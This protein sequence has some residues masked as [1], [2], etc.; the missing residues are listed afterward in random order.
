VTGKPAVSADFAATGTIAQVVYDVGRAQPASGNLAHDARL[1]YDA[2]ADSF[3]LNDGTKATTFAAGDVSIGTSNLLR[4]EKVEGNS[5]TQL[6]LNWGMRSD[7]TS[8]P[9]YVALGQ[10]ISKKTELATGIDSYR[11]VDFVFGLPGE[12]AFVPVTGSATYAL[13]FRGT[14]SSAVTEH[15]L[16][17]QGGGTALVDFSTGQLDIVGTTASFNFGG[18]G[19]LGTE[20]RGE[21]KARAAVVAGENRFTGTFTA[22]GGASDTYVGSLEGS[23]FGP[24]SED[25]GGVLYGAS[26]PLYYNLAFAGYSLPKLRSDDTLANLEGT[27]RLRTVRTW[28]SLPADAVSEQLRDAVIYNADTRTYTIAGRAAQVGF[29]FPFGAWFGPAISFGTANRTPDRDTGDMRAYG[30]A[31]A[32]VDGKV[33]YSIGIFD[34]ESH[35]IELSYTSFMRVVAT[36]SGIDGTVDGES[37]EY[38]GFGNFT[39][40]DQ[41]PRSGSAA[42]AGRLFGD[43]H[44]DTKSLA[45][46][47]GRSDLSVNF[48]AGTLAASLFPERVSADGSSAA[49]GRYDFN[50]SIDAYT[51]AFVG[52][53]NAGAGDIA[54]RFYGDR[55]QEYAAV[56]NVADPAVGKMTGVTVGKQE[57]P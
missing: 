28:P 10:L 33:Q 1:A 12:A 7:W 15:L 45:A 49:L 43:L 32:T 24:A 29:G 54:G 20:S 46:L 3:T 57:A 22:K 39:P 31:L 37:L 25:M 52:K 27:T 36:H 21:V 8:A 55:A 35:G 5:T 9:Q 41:L 2:G 16:S 26:G 47:I 40:P 4:Y 13:T 53:W 19:I 38:I 23:F 56:F 50:G 44:D 34:G 17:M 14:R 11:S 48:A 6:D 18:P 30:A 51:S 42:Y